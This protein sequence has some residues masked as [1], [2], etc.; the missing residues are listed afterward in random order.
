MICGIKVHI[1]SYVKAG[2]V[3]KVSISQGSKTAGIIS[4]LDNFSSIILSEN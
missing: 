4:F 1:K 2:K 3:S